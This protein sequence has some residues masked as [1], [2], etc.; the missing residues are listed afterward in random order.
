[1]D[2]L[3]DKQTL[4]LLYKH[5]KERQFASPPTFHIFVTHYK[6]PGFLEKCLNSLFSQECSIPVKI[7]C[8]DDC[9]EMEEVTR[10][11]NRFEDKQGHTFFCYRNTVR[12]N[13]GL[14]L[15][16]MLAQGNIQQEDVIGIVDGDDWLAS[17]T[18]LER[19]VQEYRK[20]GC[21]VTYGSYACSDGIT[22]NCTGPLN[23]EHLRSEAKGRGFRE[24]R[25]VFSHFFTAKAF[26]WYRLTTD[27]LLF[28][29]KME[30]GGAPY[31]QLFNIPIAEMASSSRI[32]YIPDILYIYNNESALN[33]LR[34]R[35]REQS[36]YDTLNREREAFKPIER[37]TLDYSIIMGCRGRFP[38]LNA[39]IQR[40]KE[41]TSMTITSQ[42][43]L[44]EH[45][46]SPSYKDYAAQQGVAWIYV[47]LEGPPTTPIGQF[48]RGLCF[49]IGF[50]YGQKA[51]YYICH[52][53][54]LLVPYDF[55][56]KLTKNLKLSESQ[57]LQT[58]SDRFVWQTTEEISKKLLEDPGWFHDG[59]DVETHC[60]RNPPGA[61]GGS[62]TISHE[63]YKKLGGHDPHLFFGYAAEDAFFWLKVEQYYT[64]GYAENP[65]IP[66]THLWHPC[67][68]NLNPFKDHMDV[69]FH[70]FRSIPNE[71]KKEYIEKKALAFEETYRQLH[72]S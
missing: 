7:H 20:T 66:L 9:S 58:Y 15:F 59:F 70:M 47:P 42:I 27:I 23:A 40:F 21:W 28:H 8:I 68:A 12:Q 16:H 17:S 14:N 62:I 65:R 54:D 63:A 37:P 33:E 30:K 69:L 71:K 1:M 51:N 55:W 29:G 43:V 36:G 19:V 11:L 26:L 45:S 41:E 50:L 72:S 44:V 18:V 3:A 13:K 6:T 48:N 39:T 4:S 32:H 10:I 2:Q 22:G 67:A 34:M 57:V 56:N 46:E 49:D 25:W 5:V 60:T 61:K 31:D 64:I 35:P 24:A 38:L 53:N 52:D